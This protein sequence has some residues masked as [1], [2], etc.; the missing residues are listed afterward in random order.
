MSTNT[1]GQHHGDRLPL[2]RPDFPRALPDQ[3]LLSL[4]LFKPC[5][6][7]QTMTRNDSDDRPRNP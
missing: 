2:A 4:T 3:A 1:A 7:P 5:L 6:D